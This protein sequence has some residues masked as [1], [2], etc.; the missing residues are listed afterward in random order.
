M[1]RLE[2][3]DVSHNKLTGSI[4]TDFGDNS[5]FSGDKATLMVFKASTNNLVGAIPTYIGNFQ[6]LGILALGRCPWRLLN[7]EDCSP[8]PL[9]DV[10]FVHSTR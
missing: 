3:F 8:Q 9:T 4:P 1:K 7:A 2:Y 6:Q 5:Q 10:F